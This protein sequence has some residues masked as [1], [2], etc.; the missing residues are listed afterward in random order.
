MMYGSYL[1]HKQTGVN[2]LNGAGRSISIAVVKANAGSPGT[3]VVPQSQILRQ[4]QC[5]G[6]TQTHLRTVE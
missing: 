1:H 5:L 2:R 4:V 6:S 3:G